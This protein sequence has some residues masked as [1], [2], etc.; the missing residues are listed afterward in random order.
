MGFC[1]ACICGKLNLYR[2]GQASL[3]TGALSTTR[4]FSRERGHCS[5]CG[6]LRTVI[7][8]SREPGPPGFTT[9]KLSIKSG[10]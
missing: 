5:L 10:R 1:N 8:A 4:D 3:I 9:E 2:E 7:R 6:N